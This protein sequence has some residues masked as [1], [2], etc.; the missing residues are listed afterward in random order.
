M[1]LTIIIKGEQGTKKNFTAWQISK[2]YHTHKEID[3]KEIDNYL[4]VISKA[5]YNT[6]KCLII[7]DV[8]SKKIAS[9]EFCFKD[10]V[11]CLVIIQ[12]I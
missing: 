1:A 7:D 8:P 9:T 5:G 10:L 2:D 4:E 12:E 6:P 3:Y 11:K